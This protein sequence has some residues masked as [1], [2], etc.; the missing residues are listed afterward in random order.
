MRPS[1]NS[2]FW[3]W[4][5]ATT[6]WFGYV[7]SDIAA[8]RLAVDWWLV[9][10]FTWLPLLGAAGVWRYGVAKGWRQESSKLDPLRWAREH[11]VA[12]LAAFLLGAIGGIAYAFA[13]FS[14]SGGMPGTYFWRW[15]MVPRFYWPWALLGAA[16]CGL[17][18][19]VAQLL[20]R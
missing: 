10:E 6:L 17:A 2:V 12:L 18:V 5:A 8:Q 1:A 9:L 20:R 3:I 16:I 7:A 13:S 4:M 15:L 14:S 11:Q 19:Y